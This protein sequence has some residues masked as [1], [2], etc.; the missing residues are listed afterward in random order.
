MDGKGR[1]SGVRTVVARQALEVCRCFQASPQPV[2][3]KGDVRLCGKGY[4]RPI[5]RVF[6]C[7]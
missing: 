5:V 6:L 4:L 1:P 2:Q 3:S 7:V